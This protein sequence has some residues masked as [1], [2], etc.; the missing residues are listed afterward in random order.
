MA[1]IEGVEYLTAPEAARLVGRTR[2]TIYRWIAKGILTEYIDM[3]K[4]APIRYLIP[5]MSLKDFTP[6]GDIPAK[7]GWSARDKAS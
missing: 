5:L 3:G 1:M 4:N 6:P 2:Q 7:R